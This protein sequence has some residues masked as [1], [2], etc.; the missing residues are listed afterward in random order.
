MRDFTVFISYSQHDGREYA[1]RLN[2]LIRS[3]FSD[4]RVFWDTQLIAGEGLWDKLHEEV[5]HCD[6][7]LYLVSDQSTTMPSGCIREY[8]WARLYEKHV[9]PC[10]LSTFSGDPSNISELPELCELL[11]IDLRNGIENCTE[12]IAKL[13]GTIYDSVV[14][15]SPITEFHRK[16]MILLYEILEKLSEEKDSSAVGRE[17][18]EEGYEFEYHSYPRIEGRVPETVC[19]EVIHILSMM[20]ALQDSWKEFSEPE[21]NQILETIGGNVDYF[22]NNVGFWVNEESDHFSYMK[23]LNERRKFTHLNYAF[24]EG[25]SHMK[26]LPRYRVML[27]EYDDIKH[28]NDNDYFKYRRN[29]SVDEMIRILQAQ[30]FVSSHPL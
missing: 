9:I 10:I 27:R 12:E 19:L 2:E 11:Y 8:S 1:E 28:D 4:I 15:A 25:N 24:D 18:Y 6:V 14:S 23:F 13:Y 29:L 5:R 26:N 7:F 17:V 22:V 3:V 16:E 20:E 21:R 30:R